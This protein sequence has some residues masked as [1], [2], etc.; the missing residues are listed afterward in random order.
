MEDDDEDRDAVEFSDQL[1]AIGLFARFVVSHSIPLL[2]NL[3]TFKCQAFQSQLE[4]MAS[5]DGSVKDLLTTTYEDLHWAI[6][7]AGYTISFE[8]VGETNLIPSEV[9]HLSINSASNTER[10]VAAIQ[11]ALNLQMSGEENVDPVVK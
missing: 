3:L 4:R 9:V 2:T 1:Q 5:G 7:I 8:G 11:N 6:L 10:S